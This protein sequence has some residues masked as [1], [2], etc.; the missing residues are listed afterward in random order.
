MPFLILSDPFFVWNEQL[1]KKN[2][3]TQ[4]KSVRSKKRKIGES[5]KQHI[6]FKFH[7]KAQKTFGLGQMKND[8]SIKSIKYAFFFAL[9]AKTKKRYDRTHEKQKKAQRLMLFL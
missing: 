7:I 8:F 4:R 5:A 2:A 9:L 3:C 6:F 1:Y